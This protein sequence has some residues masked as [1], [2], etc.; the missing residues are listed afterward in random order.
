[1]VC[2]QFSPK[3]I[4]PN[5]QWRNWLFGPNSDRILPKIDQIQTNISQIPAKILSSFDRNGPNIVQVRNPVSKK[6][7]KLESFPLN[8]TNFWSNFSQIVTKFPMPQRLAGEGHPLPAE[9]VRNIVQHRTQSYV[10]TWI[11][12]SSII[13]T[14]TLAEHGTKMWPIGDVTLVN[15]GAKWQ[16]GW[17]WFGCSQLVNVSQKKNP[18]GPFTSYFNNGWCST[19]EIDVLVSALP[20]AHS[21]CGRVP[22]NKNAT[23]NPTSV[24]IQ[25]PIYQ[26]VHSGFSWP[27]TFNHFETNSKR[28]FDD[29]R[30]K[31]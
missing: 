30:E 23:A 12:Q 20:V 21:S 13:K 3:K 28:Q 5:N 14:G 31:W 29:N 27:S 19:K 1:M 7:E 9:V 26:P 10:K 4:K 11:N 17:N 24:M 22:C 8:W 16:M 15:L 18:V 2:D 25:R 6:I